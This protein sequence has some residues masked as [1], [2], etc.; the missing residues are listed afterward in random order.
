MPFDREDTL[1]QAGYEEG[2]II[3]LI[4]TTPPQDRQAS[5]TSTSFVVVANTGQSIIP[6]DSLSPNTNLKAGIAVRL[7]PGA[8]E[9]ITAGFQNETDGEEVV[10]VTGEAGAVSLEFSGFQAYTP[11]TTSTPVRISF[12]H[13]VD[14][15][16][17]SSRS[18]APSLIIG[19]EL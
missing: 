17:N 8:G 9:T 7:L 5:T 1:R 16:N 14:Q 4:A 6:W 18:I 13:K 11:S 12:K 19:K 10:T 15:G 2:D 3:P